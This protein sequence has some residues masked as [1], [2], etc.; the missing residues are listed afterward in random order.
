MREKEL[1]NAVV[2]SWGLAYILVAFVKPDIASISGVAVSPVVTSLLMVLIGFAMIS[3]VLVWNKVTAVVCLVLA[4][5]ETFGLVACWVGFIVWNVPL[6]Y[7]V[8]QVSMA[9]MDWV[10][11]IALFYKILQGCKIGKGKI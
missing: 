3:T 1:A 5:W 10:G 7:D 2:L 11:A 8:A 6:S 9:V 4:F